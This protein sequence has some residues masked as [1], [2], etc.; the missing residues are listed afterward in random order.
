MN[1]KH[2][3]VPPSGP[4]T[5]PIAFVGE[6]PGRQE[7][8]QRR[9]F[10]GPAGMQ[11]NE[12]CQLAGVSHFECYSTNVIKDLDKPLKHYIDLSNPKKPV[13]STEGQE[14]I[15]LLKEELSKCSAN[16]IVPMGNI[17]LFALCSRVGITKWRGSVLES[18]LIPTRKVVPT[19]HPATIIPPKNQYLNRHLIVFDLKRAK[20]ES[21]FKEIRS[22]PRE[23]LIAPSFY[24]AEGYLDA[25]LTVGERGQ[26]IDYDIEVYNEEVSCIS[27]AISNL[28]VMSIPFIGP[29]GDYFTIEQEA[30]IWNLIARLLEDENIKKRGQNIAFDSHFLLRR[31]GIRVDRLVQWQSW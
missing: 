27:F 15:Q 5:A 13:V 22:I 20:R 8:R 11:R 24:K 30:N 18:T 10:V 31:Y 19:I 1:K 17:G 29:Q 12:C 21:E 23:I 3:Y 28:S 7:V 26:T 14:Y 6:Q 2:T 9:P 25:C 16:V 4:T